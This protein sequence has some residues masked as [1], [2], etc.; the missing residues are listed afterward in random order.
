M[1]N[2]FHLVRAW[3]RHKLMLG[4]FTLC[5]DHFFRAEN[6][7]ALIPVGLAIGNAV[8]LGRF[9]PTPLISPDNVILSEFRRWRDFGRACLTVS[10]AAAAGGLLGVE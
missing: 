5:F 6:R 9:T 4:I 10:E 2:E 3:N 7:Y 8:E 1:A